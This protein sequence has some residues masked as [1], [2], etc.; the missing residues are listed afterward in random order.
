MDEIDAKVDT[1][2]YKNALHCSNVR[3]IRK[4][5]QRWLS[6]HILDEDHPL[7]ESREI[8]MSEFSK[9]RVMNSFGQRQTRYVVV[10][11]FRVN[12]F[13][14]VFEAEFTLADRSAMRAP[15]LLGRKFLRHRFIVD[16]AS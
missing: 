2:A 7:Y 5:E 10:M 14:E 11:P 8:R 4:G 13:E 6:F 3:V 9:T 12:G 16:V 15:V 1:G